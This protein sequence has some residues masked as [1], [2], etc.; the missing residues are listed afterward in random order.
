MVPTFNAGD[1]TLAYRY[2]PPRL[3]RN[4]QFVIVDE[5]IVISHSQDSSVYMPENLSFLIKRMIG[6][7]GDTVTV[8]AI[9]LQSWPQEMLERISQHRTDEQGNL[10]WDLPVGHCFVK[11]DGKIS[12]DSILYGPIPVRAIKGVVVCRLRRSSLPHDADEL[13]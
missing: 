5:S 4:D 6:L 10:V 12:V 13:E 7:P 11:G 8:P 9:D 3:L 1:R 2:W